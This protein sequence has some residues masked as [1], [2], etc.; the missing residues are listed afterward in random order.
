M[1]DELGELIKEIGIIVKIFLGIERSQDPESKDV[2]VT[3]IN[4]IPI[5]AIVTQVAPE[6]L[7][8]K[9]YGVQVSEAQEIICDKK[10]LS[11]IRQSQ[12]IEINGIKF[13]AYRDNTG[14]LF[15]QDLGDYIRVNVVRK[16]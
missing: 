6:K 7:L 14:S 12:Q 15:I 10:Y 9:F 8:W 16:E 11:L 3:N 4:P 5:K 2:S 1:S 13:N